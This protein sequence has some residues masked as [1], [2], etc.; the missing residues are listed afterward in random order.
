MVSTDF[1]GVNNRD[2]D[3]VDIGVDSVDSIGSLFTGGSSFTGSSSKNQDLILQKLDFT[4]NKPP[5]TT[6]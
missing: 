3:G 2:S 6:W 1:E 5:E 4:N